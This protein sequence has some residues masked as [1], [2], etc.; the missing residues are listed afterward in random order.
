MMER[1]KSCLSLACQME[2][3]EEMMSL[4]FRLVIASLKIDF[5]SKK[6]QMCSIERESRSINSM[7]E[8]DIVSLDKDSATCKCF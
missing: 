6:R 7:D 1:S 2:V 4:T 3:E 8:V 5:S